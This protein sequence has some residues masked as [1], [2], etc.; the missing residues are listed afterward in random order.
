MNRDDFARNDWELKPEEDCEERKANKR[1]AQVDCQCHR[2][3]RV[4]HEDLVAF[5]DIPQV[6][7]IF[8]V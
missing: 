7:P 1:C 2:M 8:L 5:A 4:S 3:H 6:L